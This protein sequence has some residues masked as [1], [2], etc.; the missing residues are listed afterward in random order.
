MLKW[1]KVGRTVRAD[2]SCTITYEAQGKD[3]VYTLES[4][5]RP[6]KHANRSGSWMYT[7][8]FLIAGVQEQEFH[9]LQDAKR[10]AEEMEE[11]SGKGA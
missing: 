1:K 2:G 11:S 5:K 3:T 4:R 9:R 7:S 6:I 8:Y 10:A